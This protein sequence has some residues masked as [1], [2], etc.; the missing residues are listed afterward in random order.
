[1]LLLDSDEVSVFIVSP[2]D[3]DV[4]VE[5]IPVVCWSGPLAAGQV[6]TLARRTF[7]VVAVRAMD[8]GRAVQVTE[9]LASPVE[10][11]T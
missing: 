5:R 1:V 7:R 3:P 10:G 9:V 8:Q 4:T 2:A 6:V 11:G